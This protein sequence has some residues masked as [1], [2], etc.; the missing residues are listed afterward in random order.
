MASN[1]LTRF[2]PMRNL[3]RFDPFSNFGDL[4]NSFN[5]APFLSGDDLSTMIKLD[6][7]ET[8]NEYA[9]QAEMPGVKK[10]DIKIDIS[11]NR[12]LISSE[13]RR[14]NDMQDSSSVRTERYYGQQS[15]TL[16]LSQEIDDSRASARYEDGILTL[17][18]PK[19]T[20]AASHTKLIVH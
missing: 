12:V 2:D 16:T 13:V 6:V 3:S 14:Q 20:G 19:R 10:E 18:L 11:G 7:N 8:E 5:F 15:R 9:V 17:T 4:F 1:N